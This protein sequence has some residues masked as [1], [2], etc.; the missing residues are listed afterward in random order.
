M[1]DIQKN[2]ERFLQICHDVIQRPGVYKLLTWLDHSDFFIAP[3][4][5]R[6]HL[7]ERGGLL[8]HSLNVYDEMTRL[9]KVYEQYAD[10]SDE[11]IA[12]MALFH[13]LCKVNFYKQDTR[14][15]K[16]DGEWTT[17]PFYTI[18]E[19]FPFGG[20]GSKSMFILQQFIQLTPEEACGINCHMGL[21]EHER[22]IGAV[23][24][25]FPSAW[26]LH[27]AD[28]AATFLI[29]SEKTDHKSNTQS[30]ST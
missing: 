29:E 8:L 28:E 10:V 30:A 5:S 13:D 12:I 15:V 2:K 14:N 4:S 17:V 21:S 6:Y 22:S 1:I 20:H 9:S 24:E 18:E 27:A 16:R 23:Y 19:K 26:M 11:S 25:M 3:A 7:S